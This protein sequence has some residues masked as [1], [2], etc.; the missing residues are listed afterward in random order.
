MGPNSELIN[1]SHFVTIDDINVCNIALLSFQQSS[2]AIIVGILSNIS[3]M[4]VIDTEKLYFA[5]W[6]MHNF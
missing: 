1:K 3:P 5:H 2:V 4:S 6:D